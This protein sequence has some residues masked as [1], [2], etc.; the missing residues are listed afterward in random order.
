MDPGIARIDHGIIISHLGESRNPTELSPTIDHGTPEEKS[1]IHMML[2]DCREI[3][4]GDLNIELIRLIPILHTVVDIGDLL[5]QGEVIRDLLNGLLIVG[6]SGLRI[7]PEG[8]EITF[9]DD[10]REGL[11][12]F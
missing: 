5:L 3:V 8:E 1:G 12:T 4:K 10:L 2:F 11:T 9:S 6:E 7:I